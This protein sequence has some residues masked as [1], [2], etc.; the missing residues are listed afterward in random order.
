MGREFSYG[1]ASG[2]DDGGGQCPPRR[3]R[4]NHSQKPST[5]VTATAAVTAT[6]TTSLKGLTV[7]TVTAAAIFDL[8]KLVVHVR[9]AGKIA[10]QTQQ[11]EIGVGKTRFVAREA[12]V[13]I[14]QS[15]LML[16]VA[17]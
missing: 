2:V 13:V 7:P 1:S 15:L 14:Q 5:P 6:A 17:V 11:F 10:L 3:V 8:G 9:Q 12:H 16:C 4:K